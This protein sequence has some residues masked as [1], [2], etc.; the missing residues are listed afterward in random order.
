[1]VEFANVKIAFRTQKTLDFSRN[2]D[3]KAPRIDY[4]HMLAYPVTH[5]GVEGW[6]EREEKTG[7][8]KTDKQGYLKQSAR[9]ANQLRFKVSRTA[10]GY[11]GLAYHL[12]CNIPNELLKVLNEADRNWIVG[13]QLTVW[14]AVH[15]TLNDRMRRLPH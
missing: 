3:I 2:K 5:H 7:K 15:Q 6:C 14:R 12:P 8:L 13:Q 11:I 10:Q 1:M 9:L 4:R